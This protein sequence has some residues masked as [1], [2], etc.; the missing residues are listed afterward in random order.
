MERQ[1]SIIRFGIRV[2][3]FSCEDGES[4]R[5]QASGVCPRLAIVAPDWRSVQVSMLHVY[6]SICHTLSRYPFP[7][8]SIA[9]A[10]RLTSERDDI[11]RPLQEQQRQLVEAWM[12]AR[13]C[14]PSTD[15]SENTFDRAPTAKTLHLAIVRAESI[16]K[17]QKKDSRKKTYRQLL[18]LVD[19]LGD[20]HHLLRFIP[21]GEKYVSL[22]AGVFATVVKVSR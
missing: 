6:T 11:L 5:R 9:R 18:D 22:I 15:E 16:W 8:P 17:G 13:R 3:L 10:V 12:R 2:F 7:C 19:A 1:N 14:F 21:T 20:H 4:S